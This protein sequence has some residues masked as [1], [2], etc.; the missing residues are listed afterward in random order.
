MNKMRNIK[1]LAETDGIKD[2]LYDIN[3]KTIKKY[4]VIEEIDVLSYIYDMYYVTSY[5]R[6]ISKYKDRK[7][8]NQIS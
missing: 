5:N 8:A 6:T 7:K 4:K 2:A 1:R 3:I